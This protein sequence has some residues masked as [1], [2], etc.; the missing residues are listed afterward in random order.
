[1]VGEI[2]GGKVKIVGGDEVIGVVVGVVTKHE[3]CRASGAG[4][5]LAS[6]AADLIEVELFAEEDKEKEREE[7]ERGK[8]VLI[9]F[10]EQIVPVVDVDAGLLVIDPPKGLLDIAV[11]NHIVKKRPPR[12]LLMPVKE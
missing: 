8:R 2:V 1:M 5:R 6:V 9:P 11:V 3:L 4:D 10:V 12:G 7:G